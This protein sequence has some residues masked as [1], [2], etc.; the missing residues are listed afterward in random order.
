MVTRR[1]RAARAKK[2]GTVEPRASCE[3]RSS[4][5]LVARTRPTC[6]SMSLA[7]RF[8]QAAAAR[9]DPEPERSADSGDADSVVAEVPDSPVRDGKSSSTVDCY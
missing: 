1:E 4:P 2:G 6:F 3:A 9:R 7:L 5:V 8:Q